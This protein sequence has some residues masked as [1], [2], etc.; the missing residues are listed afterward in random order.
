MALYAITIACI[1][2]PVQSIER[3]SALDRSD[4]FGPALNTSNQ[5]NNYFKFISKVTEVIYEQQAQ[6]FQQ[7]IQG[8]T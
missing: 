5:G 6:T 3:T 2:Q 1:R 7:H 4:S 8:K